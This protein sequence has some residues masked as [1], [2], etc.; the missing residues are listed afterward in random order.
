MATISITNTDFYFV[1]VVFSGN[2]TPFVIR[3]STVDLS[4]EGDYLFFH[5]RKYNDSTTRKNVF[6]INFNDVIAPATIS[7]A[8]LYAIIYS[9]IYSTFS[10]SQEIAQSPSNGIYA[11]LIGAIDGV[12]TDFFV[13]SGAYVAGTAQVYIDNTFQQTGWSESDPSIGKITFDTAPLDNAVAGTKI[14]IVY[15]KP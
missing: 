9:Y 8:A 10:N 6:K 14:T 12:N 7:G 11:V 13:P 4:Y 3:K 15:Q 1:T 2:P 5:W